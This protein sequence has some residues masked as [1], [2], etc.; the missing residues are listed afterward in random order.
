MVTVITPELLSQ[1]LPPAEITCIREKAVSQLLLHCQLLWFHAHG[2]WHGTHWLLC[3][4]RLWVLLGH[5]ACLSPML[6]T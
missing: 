3:Q 1:S 6:P 5:Q 2:R 4:H